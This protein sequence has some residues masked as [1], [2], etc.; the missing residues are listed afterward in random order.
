MIVRYT[1]WNTLLRFARSSLRF[2]VLE[3]G[4][5]DRHHHRF[6]TPQRS[7]L[8]RPFKRARRTNEECQHRIPDIVLFFAVFESS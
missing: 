6:R 7:L 4:A 3:F 8:S 1:L 5:D 2:V